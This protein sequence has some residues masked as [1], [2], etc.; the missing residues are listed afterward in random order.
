M[1]LVDWF[2]GAK[3]DGESLPLNPRIQRPLPAADTTE[4]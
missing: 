1:R 4:S 3:R 2:P